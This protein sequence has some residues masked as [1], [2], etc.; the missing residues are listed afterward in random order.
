MVWADLAPT[1]GREQAGR[2]PVL[3]VA[4]AGYLELVTTL[5]IVVPISTI[6]RGWPNHVPLTGPV[7]AAGT[8][9]GL[10][11]PSFAL[12]EQPRTIS[13]TRLRGHL[14]R[15][16]DR[17]LRTVHEWLVDFLTF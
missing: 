16:D 14:G 12:T 10:S 11:R 2:R 4:G 8:D 1:V 3:V 9:R 6:D 15:V 7:T 13:R 17:C 5:A